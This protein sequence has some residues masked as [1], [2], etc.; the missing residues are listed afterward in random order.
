MKLTVQGSDHVTLTPTETAAA[1]RDPAVLSRAVP[2]DGGVERT[3]PGVATVMA[4]AGIAGTR[5][6]YRARVHVVE[7][8]DDRFV[9]R[10]AAA[11]EPGTIEA[12]LTVALHADGTGT[13]V[14]H[15]VSATLDGR[16]AGLGRKVLDGAVVSGTSRFL[17]DLTAAARTPAPVGVPD[18]A[19]VGPRAGASSSRPGGAP[20]PATVGAGEGASDASPVRT[21]LTA[22][23][24]GAL[25]TVGALRWWHGRR[26]P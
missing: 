9:L 1:L 12:E 16:L 17:A 14:D 11:G 22:A 24:A 25:A 13:R 21:A 10:V 7:A 5:G 20:V 6:T 19:G 2:G 15:E 4:T 3:A 8:A 23:A 18:D 26:D